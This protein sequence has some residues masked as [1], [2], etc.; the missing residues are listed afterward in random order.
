MPHV[1]DAQTKCS[2]PSPTDGNRETDLLRLDL[3]VLLF[4]RV[5]LATDH[6]NFLDVPGDYTGNMVSEDAQVRRDSYSKILQ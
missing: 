3:N 6:L 4:K 5:D 1:A 2:K